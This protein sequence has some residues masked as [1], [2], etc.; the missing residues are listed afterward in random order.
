MQKNKNS[1]II[2]LGGFV[3][4]TLIILSYLNNSIFL[5]ELLLCSFIIGLT[6]LINMLGKVE[7]VQSENKQTQ[8]EL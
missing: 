4:L 3:M 5:E 2:F 8:E 7:K 1:Y 6:T